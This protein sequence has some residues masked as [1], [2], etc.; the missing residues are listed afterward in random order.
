MK[1]KGI[2]LNWPLSPFNFLPAWNAD[3]LSGATAAI[4][5]LI[6]REKP[7]GPWPWHLWVKVAFYFI[8]SQRNVLTDTYIWSEQTVFLP[9]S[10]LQTP[11]MQKPAVFSFLSP[12]EMSNELTNEWG[13]STFTI[14]KQGARFWMTKRLVGT[15]WDPLSEHRFPQWA[16]KALEDLMYEMGK[17]TVSIYGLVVKIKS[18]I[19][20]KRLR[21]VSGLLQELLLCGHCYNYFLTSPAKGDLTSCSPAPRLF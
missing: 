20:A 19:T 16:P 17:T 11:Q 10:P 6:K 7:K 14:K 13:S 1:T 3:V 4:L 12:Q 8:Y 5:R 15:I 9:I 18:V 2:V 21:K